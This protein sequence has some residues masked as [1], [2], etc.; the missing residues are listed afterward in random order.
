[1][2][3]W[4]VFAR[5][6]L[7]QHTALTDSLAFRFLVAKF[8]LITSMEPAQ[9][10]LMVMSGKKMA[11]VSHAKDTSLVEKTSVMTS[12]TAMMAMRARPNP[13]APGVTLAW[14]LQME[15]ARHV[16]G[17]GTV[18]MGHSVTMWRSVWKGS[19]GRPGPT[20]P[21]ARQDTG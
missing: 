1:M 19:V 20:A 7:D 6:A 15:C 21:G 18:W 5:H 9:S 13:T 8:R 11:S 3:Q 14:A 16:M 4:M 10:A 2:A 12:R 17:Q